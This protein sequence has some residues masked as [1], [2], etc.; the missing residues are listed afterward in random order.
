MRKGKNKS[1]LA[2]WRVLIYGFVVVILLGVGFV[3]KYL[4]DDIKHTKSTVKSETKIDTILQAYSEKV[5]TLKNTVLY[6]LDSKSYKAIG[7]IQ[8]GTNLFLEIIEPTLKD[9]YFKIKGTEYYVEHHDVEPIEDIQVDRH[10]K[11][12]LPMNKNIVT[13][14]QFSL[15]LN[16][17]LA[18]GVSSSSLF[19][20]I[21]FGDDEYF[22]EFNDQL[23]IIKKDDVKEVKDSNESSLAEAKN[24]AVLNYHFFNDGTKEVCNEMIC[25]EKKDFEAQLKYLKDNGFYTVTMNDFN[26]WMDKKIR[27]PKKSVL[28]TV[29]DG[30]MGTDT[31]LIELLEKYDMK[32]TLFLI[33][34]WWPKEKYASPNLEI[35]SHGYDIHTAGTCGEKYKALCMSKDDL[36]SDFNKSKT[37]LD[38]HTAFCY[39]FYAYNSKVLEALKETGFKLA[40]VGG[41]RK[42]TQNDDKH[43]IP[44]FV[45]YRWTGVNDIKNMVN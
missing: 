3:F 22:V 28:L 10:Y 17:K 39:P 5:I 15:Y 45:I 29:D 24:I 11:N 2:S 30:A 20:V 38:D 8:A 25:L 41:D 27:L 31:H 9:N 43:K 12:Y 37:L 4:N 1:S 23:M 36:V 16:D 34:A 6:I 13:N 21:M 42:A 26:L 33:T 14:D 19:S 44:R 32:A 7:E 35:H 40:F 18:M